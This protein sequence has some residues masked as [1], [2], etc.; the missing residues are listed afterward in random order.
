M[1][2]AGDDWGLSPDAEAD[3]TAIT[4]VISDREVIAHGLVGLLP[5]PWRAPATI[6]SHAAALEELAVPIRAAIVDAEM[7]DA[8]QIA[9][10]AVRRGALL[11]VLLGSAADGVDPVLLGHADAILV[12]DE[13][14]PRRLQLAVTAA[15]L[16]MRL[17][18]RALDPTLPTG[19]DLQRPA[20]LGEPAQRALE[21]LAGG[22]RDAEIARELNLS[23]SAARKVI[24]RAVRHLGARTRSQAVAIAVRAGEV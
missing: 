20:A 4:V 8:P 17:F 5:R 21:L 23:E 9:A 19:G 12:H 14:D 1:Y 18:P 16:G 24:Q 6:L 2:G 11:I 3:E 10:L 7:V 22:L 13:V 15:A